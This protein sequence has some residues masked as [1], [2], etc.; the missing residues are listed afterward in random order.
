MVQV[1]NYLNNLGFSLK[2]MPLEKV[3]HVIQVLHHAH[4]NGKQ[5]FIMGNGGSAST[6]SHLVCDLAKNIYFEGL[7]PFKAIDLN[8]SNAI[9]TALANDEGYENVFAHQLRNLIQPNDIVIAISTS[10]NSPNILKAVELANRVGA[11]SIGFTGFEGGKLSEMVNIEVRVPSD[12]I[13]HVED[14]HMIIS[15]LISFALYEISR[16]TLAIQ[17]KTSKT[18]AKPT[19]IS[20]I[21][22]FEEGSSKTGP[23]VNSI[24]QAAGGTN[25]SKENSSMLFQ[26]L[27]MLLELTETKSGT[28]ILLD[29]NGNIIDGA[30]VYGDKALSPTLDQLIDISQN[31]LAGWVVKNQQSALIE[32]TSD[33]Q[34]WLR[35]PWETEEEDSKSAISVPFKSGKVVGAITLV[36]PKNNRFSIKDLE[37]VT[38]MASSFAPAIFK[39]KDDKDDVVK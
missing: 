33:D 32:S 19:K 6:A 12:N 28:L 31:G 17:V 11:I 37:L 21:G 38:N 13:R 5:I 4:L 3:K 14:I 26:L 34:R 1:D 24:I 23:L 8:S 10:G 22:S 27:K 9:F 36:R 20:E 30:Q 29:E 25:L 15:H 18:F 39:N 2:Q 35:R 7:P 16:D